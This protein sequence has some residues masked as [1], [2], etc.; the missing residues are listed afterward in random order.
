MAREPAAEIGEVVGVVG[1]DAIVTMWQQLQP[2][3][4]AE[5]AIVEAKLTTRGV[6]AEIVVDDDP[7][8]EHERAC[9][10]REEGGASTQGLGEY[11]AQIEE[12]KC[13]Q[14]RARIAT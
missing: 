7:L 14:Q 6:G 11:G 3:N 2:T 9:G 1:V 8:T 13:G 5:A 10:D 4:E 12:A